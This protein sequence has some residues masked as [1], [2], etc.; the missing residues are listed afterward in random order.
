L[1]ID[2]RE[3]HLNTQQLTWCGTVPTEETI[4]RAAQIQLILMDVDGVQTD[5]LAFYLPN[6]NGNLFETKGFH[7][8]D[9]LA[10]HLLTAGGVKYGAISGRKSAAVEERALSMGFAYMYEGHLDKVP[11]LQ[12]IQKTSG[13]GSETIA[14]VGDDFTDVPLLRSVGLACAVANARPEVKAVAHFVTN[15]EGGKGAIREVAE[16]VLKAQNKWQALLQ[17][18]TLGR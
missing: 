11:I 14:Y 5:G 2:I 12:E 18:Y 17:T 3:T 10:F 1:K 8:H 15:A 7:S 13:L 16:L 4:K 9:G 6:T